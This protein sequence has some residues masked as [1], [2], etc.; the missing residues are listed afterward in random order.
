M[1][2]K[3][4]TNCFC[5][6]KQNISLLFSLTLYVTS[7]IFKNSEQFFF[8]FATYVFLVLDKWKLDLNFA[9][10]VTL[11]WFTNR[12]LYFCQT[13]PTLHFTRSLSNASYFRKKTNIQLHIK[14]FVILKWKKFSYFLPFNFLD[15]RKT[16]H[17]TAQKYLR[18]FGQSP[19]LFIKTWVKFQ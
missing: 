9:N 2:F 10:F 3:S 17:F 11:C 8:N 13:L 19:K 18:Y 15:D 4:R 12:Y 7:G 14:I 1:S 6:I 16:L 5:D